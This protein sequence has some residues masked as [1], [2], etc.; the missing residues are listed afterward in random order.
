MAT[1]KSRRANGEGS[2]WFNEDQ[3][4]WIGRIRIAIKADNAPKNKVFRASTK[5]KCQLKWLNTQKS[6]RLCVP[7]KLIQ[8][9]HCRNILNN[10][11]AKVSGTLTV[12]Q[13]TVTSGVVRYGDWITSEFK[14]TEKNVG[15]SESFSYSPNVTAISPA[16][17]YYIDFKNELF[18]LKLSATSNVTQ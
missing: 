16:A 7:L 14:W 5:K 11:I 18:G 12:T 1:N 3:R 10:K 8:M 17:K 4:T 9:F 13:G 6:I 15:V 2:I